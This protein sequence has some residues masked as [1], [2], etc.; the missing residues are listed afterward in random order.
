MQRRKTHDTPWATPAHARP[1]ASDQSWEK[2]RFLRGRR[3]WSA[4]LVRGIIALLIGPGQRTKR[5]RALLSGVD[6][7]VVVWC[8]VV[9]CVCLPPLRDDACEQTQGQEPPR[10]LGQLVANIAWGVE[11]LPACTWQSV[12]PRSVPW[13]GTAPLNCDLRCDCGSRGRVISRASIVTCLV[14]LGAAYWPCR[15]LRLYDGLPTSDRPDQMNEC[16]AVN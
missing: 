10:S 1:E 14:L 3:G 11:F 4:S 5:A 16:S 2:A 6:G 15:H 13:N 12:A 9:V 8:G 7:M